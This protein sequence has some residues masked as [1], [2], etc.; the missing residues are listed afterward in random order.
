[1]LEKA[2]SMLEKPISMLEKPSAY[3]LS[4]GA[5]INTSALQSNMQCQ[6]S[7]LVIAFSHVLMEKHMFLRILLQ[8]RQQLDGLVGL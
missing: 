3:K 6:C 4:K 5:E 2:I 1:M 7:L 8:P